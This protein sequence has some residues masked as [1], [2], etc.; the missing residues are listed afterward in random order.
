LSY[1][2]LLLFSGFLYAEDEDKKYPPEGMEVIKVGNADF[3]VPFGTKVSKKGDLYVVENISEY[4]GRNFSN[5]RKQIV[6][7][8]TKHNFLKFD[9][10]QKFEEI[11]KQIKNMETKHKNLSIETKEDFKHMQIKQEKIE[12]AL[13]RIKRDILDIKDEIDNLYKDKN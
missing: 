1:I 6:N 11:Q 13:I 2:T 9:T 8:E 3:L 7:L 4:S 12:K 5:I 10:E